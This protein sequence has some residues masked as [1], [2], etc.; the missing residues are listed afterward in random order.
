MQHAAFD[1]VRRYIRWGNVPDLKLIHMDE[2]AIL[3]GEPIEGSRR[4]GHVIT[5]NWAADG[6]SILAQVALYNL[7]TYRVCLAPDF[8][9]PPPELT[10]GHFFN[11]PAQEI[12]ELGSRPATVS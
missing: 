4:L 6:V 12:L 9:G 7:M 1:R 3:V 11:V 10:R 8:S 2:R 5:V